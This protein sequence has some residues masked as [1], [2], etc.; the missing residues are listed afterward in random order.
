MMKKD[1]TRR[2]FIK[3]SATLV[4][5]VSVTGLSSALTSCENFIAK[6]NEQG[7]VLEI[8]VNSK[9]YRRY[10]TRTGAGLMKKFPD[11]NFGVPVIIVRIAENTYKCYSSM[12]THNN[13]FGKESIRDSNVR[14]PMGTDLAAR[15]IVCKCHGSRYDSFDDGKPYQGPAER[16]LT[17]Y[18]CEFNAETGILKIK[19]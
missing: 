13:C 2:E 11:V 3:K 17:Q 9:E 15:S 5:A 7:I 4:A 10:L 14:P 16:P 12:C 8:D 1:E 6:E 19:F 18:P